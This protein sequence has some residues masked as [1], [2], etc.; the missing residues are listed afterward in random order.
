MCNSA[1]LGAKFQPHSQIKYIRLVLHTI[2][3]II[4]FSVY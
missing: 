4:E 3:T 1:M 2:H